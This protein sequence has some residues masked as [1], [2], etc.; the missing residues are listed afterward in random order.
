MNSLK[1]AVV[2]GAL[3]AIG[4]FS[5]APHTVG[6]AT[7]DA[8]ISTQEMAQIKANQI[9][10]LIGNET[11]NDDPINQAKMTSI[12]K[13]G[14]TNLPDFDH[15]GN[16]IYA[17]VVLDNSQGTNL[18]VAD[19]SA[20]LGTT[21]TKLYSVALAI[22]TPSKYNTMYQN[23]A[24]KTALIDAL[25]WLQTKYLQDTTKGYYGNWYQWEIGVP[26]SLS[27]MLLLL[28]DDLD[29]AFI[30]TS[31]KTMD[32]YLRGDEKPGS[33]KIG[34]VNLDARQHTGANLAD[35]TLNRI[36][37]G[38]ANN[39]AP[40][41]KKAIADFKTCLAVI[42]PDN[43]QHGVTD[44]FY[45]DGS[46]IQHSTVAYTGSYGIVLLGRTGQLT[47][48]LKGTSLQS[49]TLLNT[50]NNWI[51]NSFAPLMYEGYMMEIV[52]GR[53]IS[54]T[55]SGY[56][57]SASIVESLVQLS[58]AMSGDAQH[59][60]QS[61]IKYLSSIPQL[62]VNSSNFGSRGN[63]MAFNAIMKD[64]NVS[65]TNPLTND[66][67]YAFNLMDKSVLIRPNYGFAISRSSNRVSKYEYMSGENLKSWYQGDGAFYLYQ[68][69]IDQ[70]K[71]FG[72]DYQATV[73]PNKLP[74]VTT[75]NEQRKTIPELYG[76]DFYSHEPDF[77]SGSVTQN[78]YV[79]F[80]L[81][82]NDYS[83]SAQLDQYA[84]AGMQLGDEQSYADKDKLPADFV[85]FKNA[86][87]NKAWF[88]F[89]NEIV[90]LGS[91]VHDINGRAMTTTIDNKMFD[92]G[93]NVTVNSNLDK[94][95]AA[96]K[97]LT[98]E[99]N[100]NSK[101]NVGYV[102]YDN[103]KVNVLQESR[104]GKYS[105]VRNKT[106]GSADKTVTKDYV[107]LTYQQP[108]NTTSSYAYSIVPSKNATQLHDYID[109]N[110]VTIL[111][112]TADVSAVQENSL[113]LKGYVFFTAKGQVD[114]VQ[115]HSRMIMMRKGNDFSIQ[116][117]T[118]KQTS[119]SFTLKGRYAVAQGDAQAI[120]QGNATTVTVNTAA[121]HGVSQHLTLTPLAA[122]K[123]ADKTKLQALVNQSKALKAADY[124]T[125]SFAALTTALKASE[126]VLADTAATQGTVNQTANQLQ[127]AIN[128]LQKPATAT[129]STASSA[130]QGQTT[131]KTTNHGKKV[132]QHKTNKGLPNTGSVINHALIAGGA[133][134]L[135]LGGFALLKRRQTN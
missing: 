118:N 4:F 109:Q 130:S 94:A 52:K 55:G 98:I 67:Y 127:K 112:N 15:A 13:A 126:T 71:A 108:G 101:R 93:E 113:G 56:T 83:G 29:P 27:R 110:N 70:T 119:V 89:D 132:G 62:K 76:G 45:E 1:K 99:D 97:W 78:T 53:G 95:T 41:V 50:V 22:A 74:G 51:Y 37:Q 33:P 40:R 43:I 7:T 2:A 25:Q 111:K 114:D 91:N 116:D 6:A 10:Y 75:V 96:K 100:A 123:A 121:K 48:L 39:D 102:F 9:E 36:C 21:Y 125:A 87:A 61:Y 16:A 14:Q 58:T 92:A 131:G 23:A 129:T 60:L 84:A 122:P 128:G 42:D 20:N 64:P 63:T 120:V 134:L 133:V 80:P 19:L 106:T 26:T 66:Q 124:T 59:K 38:L 24:A 90:V 107:T 104:T 17:G 35:I 72:I 31:I 3:L 68:D 117:P 77:E 85:V 34:D 135:V 44:G 82:T 88:M 49:Q 30:D 81:G 54:R 65:S 11:M 73:D 69:G 46:F 28:H 32:A 103:N 8:V 18:T 57:D 105:D 86:E 79:Y 5:A 47:T 12:A 115:S